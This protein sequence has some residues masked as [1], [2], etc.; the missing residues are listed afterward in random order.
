MLQSDSHAILHL[1]S[2]LYAQRSASFWKS[3]ARSAWFAKTVSAVLPSLPKSSPAPPKA[4]SARFDSPSLAYSI[5]RHVLVNESTCRSLFPFLP[6]TVLDARHLAC[7]PLPPPTRAN[8]YD[9]EFFR[10]VEDVLAARPRSRRQEARMLERLVPDAAFR[11]QLA[12]FWEAHPI[13]QQRFPGGLV[14][15]AQWAGQVPEDVLEDL[16]L[17][18]GAAGEGELQLRDGEMPGGMPEGEFMVDFVDPEDDDVED[19]PQ[20]PAVPLHPVPQL[21]D[22]DE[23]DEEDEDE[24]EIAVSDCE[25]L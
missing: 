21:E 19:Y 9:T 13:I 7:D 1:L 11:A 18:I 15:F 14:Q 4:F 16:F 12:G 10:G 25:G 5:Y 22:E 8:E 17:A 23:E 20:A 3:S 24:E 6:R 2:H